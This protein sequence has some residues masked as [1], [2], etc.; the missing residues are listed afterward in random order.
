MKYD[1]LHLSGSTKIWC[2]ICVGLIMLTFTGLVMAVFGYITGDFIEKGR[3][4]GFFVFVL[5]VPTVIGGLVLGKCVVTR[6]LGR[7]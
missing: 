1:K 5:L 6:F 7:S 3:S 2:D 4:V